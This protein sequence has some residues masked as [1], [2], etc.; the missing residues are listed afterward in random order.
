MLF[1]MASHGV[2]GLL[3]LLLVYLAP[4]TIFVRRLS[5]NLPQQTRV[6]AAI[7]LAVCLGFMMYGLTELMF[8]GMRTMGF[9]AVMMGWTLALSDPRAL[10]DNSTPA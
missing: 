8:R 5:L 4:A 6:A 1:A 3:A 2:F 9:Y 10:V 7:G